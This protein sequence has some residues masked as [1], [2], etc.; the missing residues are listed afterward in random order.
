M[1]DEDHGRARLRPD[2]E[3]LQVEALAR[4]L[5]ERAERLVHQQQRGREREGARDRHALLHPSRELP[6]MVPLEPGELDEL[7]HVLDARQPASRDPSRASRAAARCSSRPCASRRGRAPGT[8][9]R[10]RGRAAPACRL[11][12][13][14]DVALGRLDDVADDAQQRRLAAPRRPDQRDELAA[15]DLEVDALERSDTALA[16]DLRDAPER[17]DGVALTRVAPALG[18]RRASRR[19][20]TTRKNEIPSSAAKRF[21]AQRFVGSRT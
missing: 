5:V 13:D 14:G 17:D 12:V 1:S 10:S 9:F 3:Q 6:R 21:V 20:T 15:L 4:H 19:A 2:A 11:P 18:A 16:E 8:R 7:E